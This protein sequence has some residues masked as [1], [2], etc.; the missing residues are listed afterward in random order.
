MLNLI[1][2]QQPVIDK[3]YLYAKDPFKWKYQLL[4][5]AREKVAI[6]K[7]QNPK[8]FIHYLQTFDNVYQNSEDIYPTK[9][10]TV[11][12]A[13]DDMI[14]DME[15]NKKLSPIVTELFL[16]EGKLNISIAFYMAILFFLY[17]NNVH[18][19]RQH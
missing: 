12:I 16:R 14:A 4:I 19:T 6:K 1:K 11:L 13:F 8:A 2:N 7:L 9:K 5:N 10:R 18:C 3:I 15:A 17:N